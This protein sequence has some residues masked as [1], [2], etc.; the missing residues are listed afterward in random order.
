MR[1]LALAAALLLLAAPVLALPA[2]AQDITGQARVIDGDTL[3]LAGQRICLHGV[4]APQ[5]AQTC[6]IE[7]L[8]W[9]CG[10]VRSLQ[11]TVCA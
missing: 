10:A 5:K 2:G 4:D 1:A 8:P 7:G 11:L 3:D 6:Q 9:A